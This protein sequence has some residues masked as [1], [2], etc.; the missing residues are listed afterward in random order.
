[1]NLA[2][3]DDARPAGDVPGLERAR[4]AARLGAMLRPSAVT[5]WLASGA[6]LIVAAVLAAIGPLGTRVRRRVDRRPGRGLRQGGDLSAPAPSRSSWATAGSAGSRRG[7]L[8]VS[9]P[10]HARGARHGDHGLG[11]RPDLALRRRRAAVA[12]ALRAGR[13]PPRRRQGLGGGAE[14]F[15]AR[16]ALVRP[17]ALWRLADLRLRRLDAVRRHRRR[18]PRRRGERACCSAWCS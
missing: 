1:M 6:A 13:L 12:G 15:R 8:R 10:D 17:A 7:T 4:T 18:R 16:R 11:R 3:R 5:V 9:D 2:T 14:V